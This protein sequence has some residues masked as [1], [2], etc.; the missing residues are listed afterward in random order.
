LAGAAIS[1]EAFIAPF[2]AAAPARQLFLA[3]T[4]AQ[5]AP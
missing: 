3:R 5:P 2:N 1:Q 4:K